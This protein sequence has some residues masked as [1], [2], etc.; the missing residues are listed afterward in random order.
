[1]SNH[2]TGVDRKSVKRKFDELN[3][4]E[5]CKSKNQPKSELTCQQRNE[6]ITNQL[7][8][9]LSI[10]LSSE[11]SQLNQALANRSNPQLTPSQTAQSIDLSNRLGNPIG[12]IKLSNQQKSEQPNVQQTES[13]RKASGVYSRH[14]NQ[15][16][17]LVYEDDRND[18]E[19]ENHSMET[20]SIKLHQMENIGILEF[21]SEHSL[22]HS[23]EHSSI[24]RAKSDAEHCSGENRLQNRLDHQIEPRIELG[25]FEYE[26]DHSFDNQIDYR[27][28]HQ[29]SFSTSLNQTTAKIKCQS[30]PVESTASTNS[31]SQNAANDGTIDL[32]YHSRT[33]YAF[34]QMD[35]LNT[36]RKRHSNQASVQNSMMWMMLQPSIECPPQTSTQSACQSLN[37]TLNSTVNPS[38]VQNKTTNLSFDLIPNQTEDHE[39]KSADQTSNR[40]KNVQFT[41]LKTDL[42]FAHPQLQTSKEPIDNQTDGLIAFN[43]TN[44][45]TT[46]SSTGNHLNDCSNTTQSSI[47]ISSS[48]PS[49]NSILVPSSIPSSSSIS[50]PSSIPSPISNF[51]AN[52]SLAP[53]VIASSNLISTL[54]SI[55]SS[56][57]PTRRKRYT[58]VDSNEQE[59]RISPPSSS[60][61]QSSIIENNNRKRPRIDGRLDKRTANESV[62]EK[63]TYEKSLFDRAYDPPAHQRSE[64]GEVVNGD[65]A[66]KFN[67]PEHNS[68]SNSMHSSFESSAQHCGLQSA[69]T[70]LHCN[71]QFGQPAGSICST[72]KSN[73]SNGGNSNSG[74]SNSGNSN[75]GNSNNGKS[76]T[77]RLHSKLHNK[78]EQ[79]QATLEMKQ[80]WNEFNDLGTEMIV[81]KAGR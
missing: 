61:S 36:N 16:D 78:L 20:N 80:L 26:L 30:D 10:Q 66:V 18:K 35:V 2:P 57:E 7:T 55:R 58:T 71:N 52:A 56:I 73:A 74:N 70:V 34:N 64:I 50:V 69:Q 45:R 9:E 63:R 19:H 65:P 47:P 29:P 68:P 62:D 25:R 32:N 22:E 76:T 53:P 67:K 41:S 75:N 46:I 3:D 59:V 6:I 1:M 42:L 44:L 12:A 28:K 31:I 33:N 17:L 38:T 4:R 72:T 11:Q 8:S 48:I 40:T 77:G 14:S 37:Q 79:V 15:G 27:T 51:P 81:T 49:S 54:S 24:H 43:D 21:G 5:V 60:G 23:S 13:G 39:T